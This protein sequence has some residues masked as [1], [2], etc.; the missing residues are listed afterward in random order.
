MPEMSGFRM[1]DEMLRIKPDL[2]VLYM[3]SFVQSP[4]SMPGTPGAVVSFLEKP[5]T[6]EVLLAR[7]R[8]VTGSPG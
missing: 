2:R 7:F 5:F 4:I 1:I 8:Q 6:R 3:S